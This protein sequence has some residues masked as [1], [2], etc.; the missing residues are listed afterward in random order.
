M[1]SVSRVARG[2]GVVVLLALSGCVGA[3]AEGANIARDKVVVANNIDAARAGNAEAQYKVGDA[4]CCSL[5]EGEGFYDTPQSVDWLCQAAAQNHGPAALKLGEIYSGDVI[6]GARV[7]RRVAQGV[8]GT[9]TNRSVAYAWLRRAE[10]LGMTEGRE[11]ARNLWRSL[12]PA[13]RTDSES[14]VTGGR[15]IPCAWETVV[16]RS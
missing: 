12:S 6:S 15:E 9:S 10:T 7:M 4:L 5:N 16:G 13:E 1:N 2:V 11:P 14:M 8:A 3:V